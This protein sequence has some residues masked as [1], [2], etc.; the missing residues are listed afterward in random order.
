VCVWAGWEIEP[1]VDDAIVNRSIKG[2]IHKAE[3]PQWGYNDYNRGTLQCNKRYKR[4][5]QLVSQLTIRE[6][7]VRQS[8]ICGERKFLAVGLYQIVPDTL[9]EAVNALH[10]SR[11]ATFTPQLQDKIFAYYLV[12]IKR[13]SVR[14]YIIGNSSIGT[15]LDDMSSEWASIANR[16]GNTNYAHNRVI[17]S[18]DRT[19]RTLEDARSHYQNAIRNNVPH[20][21][22]WLTS[23]GVSP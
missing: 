2:L 11:D 16:N 12:H 18:R 17:V 4:T 22:A 9:N 5:P 8:I 23:I 10:I 19:R 15:A 14:E 20:E 13:P 3:S 1:Y 6:I 21:I 7:M